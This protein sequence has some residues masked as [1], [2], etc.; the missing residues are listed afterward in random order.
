MK[1]TICL[2]L[3]VFLCAAVFAGGEKE[4]AAGS[5]DQV[6]VSMF[7]T[8]QGEIW[9]QMLGAFEEETG[10][11]VE[12]VYLESDEGSKRM[13]IALL[14]GDK[15]DVMELS[16]PGLQ[17][18]YVKSG[19]IMPLNDLIEKNNYDVENIYGK[20][21]DYYEDDAIY[22]LPEMLTMWAVFYNKKIFD[23]AGVAYPEAP[24]TWS[25]YIETA[26][27]L[28]DP[29]NGIYGSYMLD[30]DVYSYLL[31]R[32]K[33][34]SGYDKDG[35]SNF[36]HPVFQES[37]KFFGDLGNQH[38]IQPSWLEF[39]TKKLSWDGFMSGKY[40]MHFISS[41]YLGIL[42]NKTDYPRDWDWGILEIP[43]PDDWTYQVNNFGV[44][45]AEAIN[46]NSEHPEEAFELVQFLG[47]NYY[48]FFNTLPARVDLSDAEL[49]SIFK[50]ISDSTDGDVTIE[51][52]NTTYFDN[53]LGFV[54][55]KI[56]GPGAAELEKIV[57]Q[58]AELYYIGQKSL[59]DAV[60]SIKNRHDEAIKN[61]L[62]DQ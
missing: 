49:E 8:Y 5:E 20:F 13:D 10:Y 28:N 41:W 12:Q 14:S 52:L 17:Y 11:K 19:L 47:E 45:S 21:I 1:Q 40:G 61:D 18:K 62:A 2:L 31:A 25:D 30:Y 46:A 3:M 37:M 35:S 59:E 58:E 60:M 39:K 36:H 55:E 48:K 33:G 32:Q 38:K 29:D 53:D 50:K 43:R 7:V 23:D 42:T 34:I 15:T 6:T 22:Y 26:K 54:N 51:D 4:A 56:V 16:Y 57:L 27:K 44:A 24:W 9:D